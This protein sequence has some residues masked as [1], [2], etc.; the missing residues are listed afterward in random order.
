MTQTDRK[1]ETQKD[2]QIDIKL[3]RQKKRQTVF[4]KTDGLTEN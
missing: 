1:A 4:Q 2:K 3:N